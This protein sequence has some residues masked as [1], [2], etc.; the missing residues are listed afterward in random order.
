MKKF[1]VLMLIAFC[2]V[3]SSCFGG[4]RVSFGLDGTWEDSNGGKWIFDED[5]GKCP[6]KIKLKKEKFR[7]TAEDAY[8]FSFKKGKKSLDMV[9][10]FHSDGS[11]NTFLKDSG[12]SLTFF[13]KGGS[14][15][16]GETIDG[17]WECVQRKDA[18]LNFDSDKR[19]AELCFGESKLNASYTS[20]P[21]GLTLNMKLGG[22]GDEPID[23]EIAA[24]KQD[25][26][27]MLISSDI[28]GIL[29]L[30]K[31]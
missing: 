19:E 24:F 2:V 28:L 5:A 27:T 3:F 10:V 17:Y 12:K 16:S 8:D 26:K 7:F 22:F 1:C 18:Y 13:P 23:F 15:N 14:G 29:T 30:T 9:L 31:K 21:L 11:L 4:N 20:K 6:H 25:D